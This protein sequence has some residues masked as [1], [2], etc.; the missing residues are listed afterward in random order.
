MK[1]LLNFLELTIIVCVAVLIVTP[2]I[3]YS[4]VLRV[5]DKVMEM[6]GSCD[7]IIPE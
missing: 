4:L 2:E 6:V 5:R 1:T 7:D 3:C